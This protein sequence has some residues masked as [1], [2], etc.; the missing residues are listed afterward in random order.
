MTCDSNN[1]YDDI[2]VYKGGAAGTSCRA[3]AMQSVA[4]LIQ[5][6]MIHDTSR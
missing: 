1:V 5:N 6:N 3:I 2:L 4:I